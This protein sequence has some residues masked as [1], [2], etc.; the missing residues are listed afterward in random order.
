MRS[1]NLVDLLQNTGRTLRIH[2]HDQSR[3]DS[4]ELLPHEVHKFLKPEGLVFCPIYDKATSSNYQSIQQ[5]IDNVFINGDVP[6][7]EVNK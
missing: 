1:M 5:T 6:I 7:A 2:P 4:G 3:L